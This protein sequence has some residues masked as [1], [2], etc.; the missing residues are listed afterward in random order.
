[1]KESI[2]PIIKTGRFI[3]RPNRFVSHVEIEG[4]IELC[5]MPN[6]GRMRELLFPG[7]TMY[8]TP[9]KNPKSR[10]AYRVIGVE[11]G[12]KIFYLD[13]SR[14]NDAAAYL[15]NHGK[16]PGWENCFVARREVTMG[17]SRFDLLL[18]DRETGETFPVEVKS[19]SLSGEKG[20]MFPDAPTERGVKHLRHLTDMAKAGEHA[21][22][23]ILV[24]D[25]KA[26][27]F[28]PDMHTDPDFALAFADAM[29]IVDW[30]AAAISWT[31]DFTMP[32]EARLLPSSKVAIE[33]EGQDRGAYLLVLQ[34]EEDTDIEGTPIPA[35]YYVYAGWAAEHLQKEMNHYRNRRKRAADAVDAL[36]Q[37]ARLI[38]LFPIRSS[39]NISAEFLPALASISDG[40]ISISY[41]GKKQKL[42]AF[43]ENPIHKKDFTE[44]EARFQID[45]LDFYF[46][47]EK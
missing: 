15:V 35:G 10:T 37:T 36:R 8:V 26:H 27:W 45:R 23:L 39:E 43:Q 28:L 42:F 30:K 3:D 14:C 17:D 9:S 12:E 4:E 44:L 25:A 29:D 40:E 2:Y 46:R 7:V 6:P 38:G 47:K 16:I 5:H 41:G 33:K 21:G 34:T 31:P 20:A 1:M 13:T 22:L 19:C 24:H 18:C 32:E 11:K